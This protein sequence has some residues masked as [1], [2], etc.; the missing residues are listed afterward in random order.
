MSVEYA[1]H[2]TIRPDGASTVAQL[3]ELEAVLSAHA[4]ELDASVSTTNGG[5]VVAGWTRA[6]TSAVA[7]AAVEAAVVDAATRVGLHGR[8]VELRIRTAEQLEADLRRPT[9]PALLGASDVA[10]LLGVSRQRVHQLAASHP[11]FPAPL[12]HLR[13][14]PLWSE[15]AVEAF[16]RSWTRTPGRRPR[17]EV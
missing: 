7:G 3:D 12:V 1:V 2:V 4:V 10:A 15:A 8:T 5:Y 13:M 17:L 14:G 11:D 16:A 9:V 6:S